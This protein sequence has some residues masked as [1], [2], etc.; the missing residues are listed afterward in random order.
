ML[1]SVLSGVLCGWS[2]EKEMVIGLEHLP[3]E[4]IGNVRLYDW[5]SLV[6]DCPGDVVA[7]EGAAPTDT[8]ALAQP[9]AAAEMRARADAPEIPGSRR[10][11]LRSRS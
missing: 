10:M 5:E 2:G 3:R 7:A 11:E 1:L 4:R 9:P 8:P 6:A